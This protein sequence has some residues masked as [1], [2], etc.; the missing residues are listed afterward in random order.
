LPLG[1]EGVELP[2]PEPFPPVPVLLDPPLFTV[3]IGIVAGLLSGSTCVVDPSVGDSVPA[4]QPAR[5]KVKNK[6]NSE[7]FLRYMKLPNLSY[8]KGEIN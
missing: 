3:V 4:P 7:K 8:S 6:V 2:V 5:I 1:V